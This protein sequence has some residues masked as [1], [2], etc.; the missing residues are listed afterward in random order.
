MK[1]VLIFVGLM[2][3]FLCL[4]FGNYGVFAMTV[5]RWTKRPIKTKSKGKIVYMQPK[6]TVGEKVRCCIPMWQA[7]EVHKALYNGMGVLGV[8]GI[9]AMIF[10]TINFI[11]A[12]IL[13]INGL[14][15]FVGHILF[16]IGFPIA[17]VVY[18]IIT[19][20]CARLYDFGKLTIAL[21]FLFPHICCSHV[22]NN[23]PRIMRELRR[24][25]TFEESGDT[26]IKSKS[27]K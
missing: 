27:G 8:L 26:V 25:K 21:N 22:K 14:V 24:D 7:I 11:T 23:I 9:V 17:C 3:S 19:A 20:N 16:F 18:G 1:D 13:P 5:L 4:F 10:I 15:M 6:L 2:L 12:F